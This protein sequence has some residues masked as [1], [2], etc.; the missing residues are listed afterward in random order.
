[1]LAR[2]DV[3]RPRYGAQDGKVWRRRGAGTAETP[4]GDRRLGRRGTATARMTRGSRGRGVVDGVFW[5]T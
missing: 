1:V 2:E 4:V 3:P 5:C